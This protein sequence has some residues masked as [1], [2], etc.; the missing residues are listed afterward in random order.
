MIRQQCA[1]ERC[2]DVAAKSFAVEGFTFN[3]FYR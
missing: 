2:P 3:G 1:L